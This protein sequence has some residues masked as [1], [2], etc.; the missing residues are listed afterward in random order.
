MF[1]NLLNNFQSTQPTSSASQPQGAS[2]SSSAPKVQAAFANSAQIGNVGSL[3]QD[4][5]SREVTTYESYMALLIAKHESNKKGFTVLQA[6]SGS[7]FPHPVLA[8]SAL[9]RDGTP[10][11]QREF[12]VQGLKN[13]MQDES[14]PQDSRFLAAFVLLSVGSRIQGL[15]TEAEILGLMKV[16]TKNDFMA[17]DAPVSKAMIQ[18]LLNF[19]QGTSLAPKAQVL[20]SLKN[21]AVE[22]EVQEVNEGR[23]TDSLNTETQIMEESLG[24]AVVVENGDVSPEDL[25]LFDDLMENLAQQGITKEQLAASGLWSYWDA[26]VGALGTAVSSLSSAASYTGS[27]VA[28]SASTVA[29]YLNPWSYS[30]GS[31][32]SS[33]FT[34]AT[35]TDTPE[36]KKSDES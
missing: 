1:K 8:F 33:S 18:A 23:D 9:G 22:I 32:S 26:I 31:S 3:A 17:L 13:L 24:A 14:I 4:M 2:S 27:A 11:N 12:L 10:R 29:S 7:Y 6:A 30:W 35:P 20:L 34:A 36:P 28:G 25:A 21:E 15:P 19:R 16:A 5:A